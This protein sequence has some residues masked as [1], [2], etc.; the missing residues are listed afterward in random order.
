LVI[1]AL[2][3]AGHVDEEVRLGLR[4]DVHRKELHVTRS[5]RGQEGRGPGTDNGDIKG[6]KGEIE[7]SAWGSDANLESPLEFGGLALHE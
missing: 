2:H 5:H 4:V 3:D 7:R 1:N 6:R